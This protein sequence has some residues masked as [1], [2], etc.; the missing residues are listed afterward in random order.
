MNADAELDAALGRKTGIAFDVLRK[1]G[2][3]EE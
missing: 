2:L 3:P 1:A